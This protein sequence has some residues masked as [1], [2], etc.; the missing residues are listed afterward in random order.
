[1]FACTKIRRRP[2]FGLFPTACSQPDTATLSSH[3]TLR[4][5]HRAALGARA[6]R[7]RRPRC[8]G[9]R[10]KS[11]PPLL[12]TAALAQ[13]HH[14]SATTHTPCLQGFHP[15]AL[16]SL[17]PLRRGSVHLGEA[18]LDCEVSRLLLVRSVGVLFGRPSKELERSRA[19]QQNVRGRHLRL[20]PSGRCSTPWFRHG[21]RLP[22]GCYLQL[23]VQAHTMQ[24][25]GL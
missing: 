12:Y 20:R 1:M 9:T 6:H 11:T 2:L 16:H 17:G 7:V 18:R 22:S 5:L 21:V 13:T 23:Y 4:A 24:T 25:P 19:P 14:L 3:G 8:G 15:A 10:N